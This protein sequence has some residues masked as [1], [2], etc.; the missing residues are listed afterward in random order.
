MQYLYSIYKKERKKLFSKL[1]VNHFLSYFIFSE[2]QPK[3]EREMDQIECRTE[4]LLPRSL[5][6]RQLGRVD[7]SIAYQSHRLLTERPDGV[8][9]RCFRSL[10]W[11]SVG[12]QR[13]NESHVISAEGEEL[14]SDDCRHP[15]VR[16]MEKGLEI[17]RMLSS[18]DRIH[19]DNADQI[20]DTNRMD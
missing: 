14:G 10:P 20:S 18:L 13:H 8:D 15:T 7:Y 1:I 19:E 16:E 17:H 2:N 6:Q 11:K 5:R 3:R 4:G 12:V 9:F